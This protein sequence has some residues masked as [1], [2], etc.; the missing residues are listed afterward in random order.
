MRSFTPRELFVNTLYMA[1]HYL[2][3]QWHP[4]ASRESIRAYQLRQL[5]RLVAFAYDNVALYREKYDS[6]GVH[7]RDLRALSDLV[8]FP[9]VSK[10]E[11][12]ST[13]ADASFPKAPAPRGRCSL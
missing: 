7:P 4:I 8:H 13:C 5:Q 2:A 3:F 10:D 6:A 1:R 9:I 12:L 11:A